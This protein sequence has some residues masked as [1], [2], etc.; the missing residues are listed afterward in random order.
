[1]QLHELI[2][3]PDGKECTSLIEKSLTYNYA[4]WTLPARILVSPGCNPTF[5]RKFGV[6]MLLLWAASRA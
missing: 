6:V 1:M 3:T 4:G 5:I 2:L